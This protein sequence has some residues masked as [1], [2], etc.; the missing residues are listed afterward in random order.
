MTRRTPTTMAKFEAA[1]DCSYEDAVRKACIEGTRRYRDALL[2]FTPAQTE[3][4]KLRQLRLNGLTIER[5]AQIMNI[6]KSTVYEAVN[7][8]PQLSK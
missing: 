7:D 2:G 6:P 4:E 8:V 1:S 3:R 5:I